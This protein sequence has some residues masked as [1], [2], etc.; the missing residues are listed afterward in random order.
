MAEKK[1]R[2]K[3]KV[4]RIITPIGVARYPHVIVPDTKWKPEGEYRCPLI[5][6]EDVADALRPKL[7]AFLD[8]GFEELKAEHYGDTPNSPKA[9]RLKKN[10]LP[11]KAHEDEEGNETGQYILT[12]KRTASGTKKDGSAWKAKID[13]VDSK[14]KKMSKE[15]LSIWGGSKLRCDC[16]VFAW[17]SPKDNEVGLKLEIVGVQVIELVAGGGERESSFGEVEGGY[18]AE[19]DAGRSFSDSEDEVADEDDTSADF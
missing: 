3:I 13:I 17:F 9:K 6:D 8:K 12:P 16:D 4:G 10:D 5:Y 14:G 19:D 7:Q 15:G 11:I 18:V 1:K 2:N